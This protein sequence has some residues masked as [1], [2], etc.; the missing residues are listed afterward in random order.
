MW[1]KWRHTYLYN[2]TPVRCIECPI[3]LDI[4]VW[5]VKGRLK[6]KWR[7][8]YYSRKLNY[9]PVNNEL[10]T[11]LCVHNACMHYMYMYS[12]ILSS[13]RTTNQENSLVHSP[14]V[15][16]ASILTFFIHFLSYQL[17]SCESSKQSESSLVSD[18]CQEFAMDDVTLYNRLSSVELVS[19]NSTHSLHK[20]RNAIK[21]SEQCRILCTY[22]IDMSCRQL[23]LYACMYMYVACRNQV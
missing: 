21:R 22:Y 11:L 12:C 3:E 8:F 19:D 20:Q 13:F 10:Q 6:L 2:S 7:H 4:E 18:T 9:P 14:V 5:H 23:C 1:I 17:M 16:V 15:N